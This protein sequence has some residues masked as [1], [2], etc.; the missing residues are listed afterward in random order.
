MSWFEEWFD[1]PLYEKLYAYRNEEEAALLAD[2]IEKEVPA[3]KYP[4]L[5]D[6]GCGRGRHS[7]TLAS[8]GYR[9]TG[10]D[11][12]PEAIKSA[13]KK[14]EARGLTNVTFLTQDMRDPVDDTFDAVVNLFTTFGY[15]L[16]DDENIRVLKS[17][18]KMLKPGG[19]LLID[20]LN[21]KLV[22][23]TLVPEEDGH[24]DGIRFQV[25]RH[26][27]NG[28]VFK[29]IRFSGGTLPRPVEYRERVKLYGREWFGE[30]FRNT[31]FS[32]IKTWG[33]YHGS[34]FNENSSP[35]LIMIA[36]K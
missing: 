22:R 26:I 9:V 28:M 7:L 32:L 4:K 8:R 35:R 30:Q 36:E 6:L 29:D 15:F 24:Y 31:G 12:S 16:D 2:L 5:L 27:E 23:D 21:A 34:E 10:I 3:D 1:S 18:N 19:L 17:V 25:Q 13:K 33:D 11:L 14:A 20:F